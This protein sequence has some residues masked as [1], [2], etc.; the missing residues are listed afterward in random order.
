[1]PR[2]NDITGKKF[3]K[4]TAIK[5][6]GKSKRGRYLWLCKCEC[7]GEKVVEHSD[8]VT[9]NTK[10][11]G[12]VITNTSHGMS[13][14][15]LYKKW[16]D[17]KMRCYNPQN[18]NFKNYGERGIKMCEKWKNDFSSFAIWAMQ[19]GYDDSAPR[20][21]YTIDRI[22]VNGD[23]TP[24]NCRLVNIQTQERNKRNTFYA[25]YH[26][27]QIPIAELCAELNIP[28]QTVYNRIVRG[29]TF[30]MAVTTHI[31]YRSEQR[32]KYFMSDVSVQ[33]ME[34]AIKRVLNT[35]NI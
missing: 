10:T 16:T 23:Y 26:G 13:R 4:L 25:E 14:S 18:R 35:Q 20:G 12:C 31:K 8:L 29:W 15:K 34:A 21:K 11:C 30:E 32:K 28:S 9:G 1:M 24:E 5:R 33:E 22:D 2:I 17:I 3:G 27:F 7:G 19:N 6:V